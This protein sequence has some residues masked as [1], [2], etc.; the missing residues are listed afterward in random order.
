MVRCQCQKARGQRFYIALALQAFLVFEK[1]SFTTGISW[2]VS[3]LGHSGI[4]SGFRARPSF[5]GL[6]PSAAQFLT[7]SKAILFPPIR[8]RVVLFRFV[9]VLEEI[10]SGYGQKLSC[11]FSLRHVH[12]AFTCR[13]GFLPVIPGDQTKG[14]RIVPKL[15]LFGVVSTPCMVSGQESSS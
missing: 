2:A 10:F 14:H 8:V 4:S 3:G 6:F 13:R 12:K 1:H 9:F 7:F 11:R 5:Q 15:T